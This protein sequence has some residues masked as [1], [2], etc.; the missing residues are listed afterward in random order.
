MMAMKPEGNGAGA[1]VLRQA[2]TADLDN[3]SDIC[4]R[5]KAYWGY[6]SAFMA[7]C[8]DELTI[9]AQD[10]SSSLVMVATDA[11]GR[12]LAMS[13]TSVKDGVADLERLFVDPDAIGSGVG[14]TLLHHAFD[15]AKQSGATRMTVE[16]DPYAARFY[17][18]HGAVQIGDIPSGSIAGRVLPL[19]EFQL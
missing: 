15:G 1:V 17:K 9:T 19:L 10:L 5:S 13:Q 18:K 3:L 14:E 12:L 11:D 4:Q 7:A 8:V 16:S 2:T 6:D